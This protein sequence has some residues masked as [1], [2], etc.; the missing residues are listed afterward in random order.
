MRRSQLGQPHLK[1]SLLGAAAALLTIGISTSSSVL[2]TIP[3]PKSSRSP[4]PTNQPADLEYLT[5]LLTYPHEPNLT[6]TIISQQTQQGVTV[7]DL[8]FPS[9]TGGE[10][11]QAYLV[12]P[13]Y[14][15]TSLA[16][17][18]FVHWYEPAAADS[19]RTQYLEEAK[20]LAKRG[21]VSLLVSTM[22]SDVDW[23]RQRH[24]ANDF[25]NSVNQAKELRHALDVLISQP[26]VDP[27]RIGYVGHDFGAMFGAV[28]AAIE[29]RVRAYTLI[30]GA[31]RF[32]DWYL[33]GSADPLPRGA[34]LEAYRQQLA[35]LDP[36]ATLPHSRAA[37]FLQFGEDDFYTPQAN[38][39]EFYQATPKPAR[40]AT[41]PSQHDMGDPIIQ[42]DRLTWL[43]QEL[44]LPDEPTRR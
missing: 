42:L 38:F 14:S 26:D 29:T 2:S 15:K 35:P 36:V 4:Q 28:I 6:V 21:T 5:R 19:N 9:V 31:A 30:A 44:G 40:I 8:T 11:I 33:F 37:H 10:P 32:T 39:L 24:N 7:I 43:A 13:A 17:V 3:N 1:Q 16:G 12:R 25:I 27:A 41:Y 23:F 18:L 22:W 34:A 20:L